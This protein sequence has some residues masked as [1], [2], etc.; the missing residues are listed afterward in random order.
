M[1]KADQVLL[2]DSTSAW[3]L[4]FLNLFTAA[5]QGFNNLLEM[6]GKKVVKKQKKLCPLVQ[7]TCLEALVG[8]VPAGSSPSHPSRDVR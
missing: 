5:T 7:I 3:L 8:S 4:F 6:I 2:A 1:I